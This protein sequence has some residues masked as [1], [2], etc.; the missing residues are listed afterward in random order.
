M[1]LLPDRIPWLNDK[2]LPLTRPEAEDLL[3]NLYRLYRGTLF[4]V[5]YLVRVSPDRVCEEVRCDPAVVFQLK[6]GQRRQ[7]VVIETTRDVMCGWAITCKDSMR[8]RPLLVPDNCWCNGPSYNLEKGELDFREDARLV[9]LLA[10]DLILARR[11][12][13]SKLFRT[14]PHIPSFPLGLRWCP[15]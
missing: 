3:W 10:N 8:S 14:L 1:K 12:A 2:G 7:D 15:R 5:K 4:V 11:R 6:T 13:R 9:K